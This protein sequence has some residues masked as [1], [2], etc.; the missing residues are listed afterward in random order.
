M[1]KTLLS[2]LAGTTILF[3]ASAVQAQ[4]L[5][6]DAIKDIVKELLA[7]EPSLVT[8]ALEQAR[9][10]AQ[11]E[12]EEQAAT[13]LEEHKDYFA[14]DDVLVIGNPEGD[15]T[16]VEFFDYNCGYCKRAFSDLQKL[17]EADDNVRV[18]MQE[19]PILGPSSAQKA[20]WAVAA[21]EQGKYLEFHTALMDAP[22]RLDD[23]AL[24]KIAEDLGLDVEKLKVDLDSDAV[25]NRIEKSKSVARDVGV[26]GTPAFVIDGKFYPGYLGPGGLKREVD[27]ARG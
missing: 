26:T 10:E 22:G 21:Y 25:N 15:V 8:D 12:R 5:D 7:E 17:I 2:L 18:V 27:K 19:M 20:K 14:S 9:I 23:A 16:V 6:K 3:S 24:T 11:R 4:E 1:S 13:K